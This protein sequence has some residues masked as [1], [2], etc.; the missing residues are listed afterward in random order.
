MPKCA[1]CSNVSHMCVELTCM[2]FSLAHL[3]TSRMAV[4]VTCPPHHVLLL[5]CFEIASNE[6]IG[7]TSQPYELIAETKQLELV[8][9]EPPQHFHY[10][11]DSA[12]LDVHVIE[13]QQR[14]TRASLS[15]SNQSDANFKCWCTFM[16]F[17]RLALWKVLFGIL[18]AAELF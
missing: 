3:K 14:I 5:H 16:L 6:F 12:L 13:Q 8:Y 9:S 2:Q 4:D 18:Q 10:N 7:L 17:E 15:F 11:T 1:T